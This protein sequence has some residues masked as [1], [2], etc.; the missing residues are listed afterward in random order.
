MA[1]V[2]Q[3]VRPPGRR[4]PDR[5]ARLAPTLTIAA[6]ALAARLTPVLRGGG[7]RG[8]LA[9][10]DGVYYS[11]SDALLSGRL[12]YRDYLLLHP[13]GITLVLA[14]FAALGRLTS[15]PVGFA[16]AR[17]AFMGL[18]AVS[19]VLVWWVARRVT[20]RAGLAAGLFYAVWQPA[21]AAE[22]TTLLEPLVI[23]GVLASLALL[24]PGASRRRVAAAG[25]V[26]GLEVAVK[27]W[28]VVPFVVL[29]LWLLR[30]RG[31]RTALTYAGSG[32][33]AAAVVCLPF[34]LA[35]GA[36]ML[37]MVILDQ[38]GRPNNGVSPL[39]RLANITALQ[40]S[41]APVSHLL[42]IITMLVV[43]AAGVAVCL[44]AT[45]RPETRLWAALLGAE[46]GLLLVAPSYFGH[47]GTFVA[48]PLALLAGAG[49]DAAATW[50]AG[51]APG[52]SAVVPVAGLAL[53]LMASVHVVTQPEGRRVPVAT[54]DSALAGAH[55]VAADSAAALVLA[56]VLTRDL[57]DHCL[58]VVDVTG[59]T[60]DQD[61][62]DLPSGRTPSAR[63]QDHEWQRSVDHYLSAADAVVLDQWRS[64]G[65]DARELARLEH[66]DLELG[67]PAYRVLVPAG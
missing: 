18:G 25:M 14:P 31:R 64:D 46:L 45:R 41:P 6:V 61:R 55:C 50:A 62:G 59:L 30:R 56:D 5:L 1:V 67:K 22:R 58:V 32:A 17:L 66:R 44:L 19:A 37:R 60:Y 63:R 8:V 10:D 49:A 35:A 23:L 27:A 4:H 51:W 43:G 39:S 2:D 21:C 20:P 38:L 11:A 29:T 52:W 3:G 47:Y 34:L 57:R 26:L 42:G 33:T 16:A 48:V 28:A 36:A 24:A 9:Y 54:V 65:L 12:P 15:D 7:L 13:P 40:P 53:L